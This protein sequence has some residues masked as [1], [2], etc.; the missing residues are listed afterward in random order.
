[1]ILGL[2]SIVF[3]VLRI[4]QEQSLSVLGWTALFGAVMTGLA[5]WLLPNTRLASGLTLRTRLLT[6]RPDPATGAAAGPFDHLVGRRGTAASDLRPAGIAR[7]GDERLDVVT[8]G[9]FIPVGTPIEVYRVE[10]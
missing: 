8:Q 3:A 7:I 1:G 2:A 10:G 9:N 4:F 6:D 5:I